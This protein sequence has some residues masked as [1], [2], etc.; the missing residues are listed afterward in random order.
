MVDGLTSRLV[1]NSGRFPLMS[2]RI[3]PHPAGHKQCPIG[4]GLSA[5]EK[6]LPANPK[7]IQSDGVL[8][9]S[10]EGRRPYSE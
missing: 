4:G 5:V 3:S 7:S 8:L 2:A 1:L 10:Q 6:K 9:H